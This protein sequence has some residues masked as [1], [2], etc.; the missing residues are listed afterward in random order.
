M[1]LELRRQEFFRGKASY[2]TYVAVLPQG[3][4]DALHAILDSAEIRK[5]S[6]FRSPKLPLQSAHF[7]WFTA[8]IER[9]GVVHKVGYPYWDGDPKPSEDE[10]AAW[11]AQ[12]AALQPLVQWS[13]GVKSLNNVAWR[14]AQNSQ[15]VCQ[16]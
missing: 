5:L 16:P 1:H 11:E 15:S 8:E 3:D 9:E 7:G 12:R 10:I 2:S 6:E 14:K 4:L 13:R